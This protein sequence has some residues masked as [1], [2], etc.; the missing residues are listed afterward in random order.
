MNKIDKIIMEIKAKF[1][2]KYCGDSP[3]E[4]I[5]FIVEAKKQGID[6][7]KLQIPDKGDYL[8]KKSTAE[9]MWEHC[10]KSELKSLVEAVRRENEINI[11]EQVAKLAERNSKVKHLIRDL[12]NFENMNENI[13]ELIL[14]E[15]KLVK[16]TVYFNQTNTF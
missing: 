15:L 10:L 5:N 11:N 4:R 2:Y 14:K 7:S 16:K 1:I 8:Q 3:E 13:Q 12:G 9:F 6:T